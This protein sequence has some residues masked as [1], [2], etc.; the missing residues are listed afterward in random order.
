MFRDMQLK[1]FEIAAARAKH[2]RSLDVRILLNLVL[3]VSRKEHGQ[4]V[5]EGHASGYNVPS[6]RYGEQR[7]RGRG[8]PVLRSVARRVAVHH[9]DIRLINMV[10]YRSEE[11]R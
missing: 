9:D 5:V 10:D 3:H 2:P 7:R 6:D 1:I 11:R 4:Q 8:P